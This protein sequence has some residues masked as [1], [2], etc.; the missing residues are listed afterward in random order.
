MEVKMASRTIE[1]SGRNQENTWRERSH[2][3]EKKAVRSTTHFLIL[4]FT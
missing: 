4:I 2:G 3:T 1:G